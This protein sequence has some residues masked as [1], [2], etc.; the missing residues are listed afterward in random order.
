VV[1]GG[2]YNSYSA[3]AVG[4]AAA[5]VIIIVA[6]QV[7]VDE[8]EERISIV[9]EE[10]DGSVEHVI[11]VQLAP[12]RTVGTRASADSSADGSV[13]KADVLRL[14]AA[15]RCL[16]GYEAEGLGT[17]SDGEAMIE[18]PE[19]LGDIFCLWRTEL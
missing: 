12:E 16:P 9:G 11:E 19:I 3:A 18:C 15:K 1:A 4:Q 6:V 5:E 10:I 13:S 17:F 8:D 14:A 2:R 7:V